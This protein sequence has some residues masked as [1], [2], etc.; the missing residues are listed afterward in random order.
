MN[1]T[2]KNTATSF[3]EPFPSKGPKNE[4]E[5]ATQKIDSVVCIKIHNYFDLISL[6]SYT[7]LLG[8]T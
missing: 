3:P 7:N 2:I 5:N 4:V 1:Q 6:Q 8:Q